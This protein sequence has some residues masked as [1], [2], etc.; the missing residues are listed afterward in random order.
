MQVFEAKKSEPSVQLTQKSSI[1]NYPSKVYHI[2]KPKGKSVMIELII[3]AESAQ[4]ISVEVQELANQL[5]GTH[6]CEC[7]HETVEQPKAEPAKAEPKKAAK[8]AEKPVEEPAPVVE[9][10]EEA[11]TKVEPKVEEPAKAEEPSKAVEEKTYT[12][13]EVRAAAK[14]FVQKDPANKKKIAEFL[15][16]GLGVKSIT[17]APADVYPRII[18][19]VGAN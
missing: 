6:K 18:E 3:K 19:F 17:E 10:I 13:D 8:K 9:N 16:N 15:H 1:K 12:V 2:I 4:E 14:D 5:T 7:K 11:G